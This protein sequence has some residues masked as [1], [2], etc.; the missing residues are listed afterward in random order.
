MKVL[1]LLAWREQMGIE[2]TG[3]GIRPPPVLKTEARG[4]L[5]FAVV[6]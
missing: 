1:F 5:M 2:P 3:D 4:F 6:E